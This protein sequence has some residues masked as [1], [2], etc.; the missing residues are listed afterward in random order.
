M[1]NKHPEDQEFGTPID[2]GPPDGEPEEHAE[3]KR[4]A[5]VKTEHLEYLDALRESGVT[6]MFGARP[7]V[8]EEF[9]VSKRDATEILS[10]WMKSFGD[11]NR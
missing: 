8:E 6:N 5:M 11:P 10:Y 9:D 4:P 2:M 7:Y 3:N 1:N